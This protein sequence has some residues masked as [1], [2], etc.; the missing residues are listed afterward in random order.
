[1]IFRR[2]FCFRVEYNYLESLCSILSHDTLNYNNNEV[3]MP[4]LAP[5]ECLENLE[6]LDKVIFKQYASYFFQIMC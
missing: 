3:F 6:T 5:T 2:K 1:M 4:I